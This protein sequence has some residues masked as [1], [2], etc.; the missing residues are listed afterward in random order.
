MPTLVGNAT[1]VVLFSLT[2]SIIVRGAPTGFAIN[3]D[4]KPMYG[5]PCVPV[6]FSRLMFEDKEWA[7]GYRMPSTS[8]GV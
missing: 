6:E 8:E 2:V 1:L 5:S 4:W 3:V 7:L